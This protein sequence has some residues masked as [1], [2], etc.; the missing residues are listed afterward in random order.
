VL[1]IVCVS[2]ANSAITPINVKGVMGH[3]AELEQAAIKNGNSRSVAT[4]YAD[5]AEYVIKTLEATGQFEVSK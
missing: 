5:S 2:L 3:L 1:L 4:G